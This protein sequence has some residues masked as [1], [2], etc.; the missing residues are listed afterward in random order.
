MPGV[1]HAGSRHPLLNEPA[2]PEWIRRRPGAHWLVVATVCVGAFMGQLDASVVTVAF[3]TL[4]RELGAGLG[5]VEWVALSYLLVL[6]SSVTAI[7]RFADMVGRKLLYTYGFAVFTLASVACAMAPNLLTL[8]A[9]RVVQAVGAAM[10]QANSVA[11]IATSMPREELGRGIG[12]QGA[13]QALGLALGPTVGGL[14][15]ALGG[16]RLIF[17]VN[18][19]AGALGLLL[20]WFLLPRSRELQRRTPFDWS[21][22][23]AFVPAIG[24]LLAALSLGRELGFGS[25][26]ILGLFG[27]AVLA[28]AAFLRIQQRATHPMVDLRLFRQVP[29]SAGIASGLLSY[30]VLFGVLFVVPF[31]FEGAFGL[32]TA[33][34]GLLL[35]ALPAALGVT[36]PLAGRLAD[37]LGARPL[38]VTGMVLTA[39]GLLLAAFGMLGV[40]GSAVALVIMGVGLG[41]F[42]PP[43]NAAI[44]GSA[45]RAQ[46]GAAGGLLNMTRGIG[47]ALGVALA[48]LVYGLG[49]AHAALGATPAERSSHGFVLTATMLACL[50]LLAAVLA[51]LRGPRNSDRPVSQG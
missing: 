42:T 18:V 47:T 20:G 30:A 6:V 35:T 43:N 44:M 48:A 41:L 39:A 32:N 15:I 19:P 51:A 34:S 9:F 50:A 14:L 5:A 16:W 29:F 46:S 31:L 27:L 25:P 37:R 23:V 8:D 17:Y 28:G 26:T 4:Q 11:L 38:T 22:L 7:G 1:Q 36:A 13:A 10:L 21:G 33:G 12:V 45:P 2:R 40:P 3:P 24:A 49:T